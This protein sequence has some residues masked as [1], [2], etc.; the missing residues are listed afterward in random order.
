[1]IGTLVGSALLVAL[2]AA[3]MLGV[4]RARGR[5]RALTTTLGERTEELYVARSELKRL[6]S[7]DSLTDIPNH[8]YFQDFLVCEWRRALRELTPISLIVI[9]LDHFKAYNERLGS[10]AGDNC[11]RLV[12]G[13]LRSVVGRPGDLVARYGGEEFVVVLGRTDSDGAYTLATK[14]RSMVEALELPHPES[15]TADRVTTSVGVATMVP[16]RN[17][18]WQEIELIAAAERA[19][20][21]AK[22]GGRNRVARGEFLV[23]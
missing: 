15:P 10:Q 20:S 9:D 14:L 1:M 16:S 6:A 11:L 12:A 2:A 19:L 18:T 3:Y 8:E 17:T 7:L 4:W 21:Q 5:E 22:E 13:A 23:T